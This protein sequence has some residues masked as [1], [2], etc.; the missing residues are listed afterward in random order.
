MSAENRTRS[1]VLIFHAT[2]V[3]G[4]E[5]PSSIYGSLPF[6]RPARTSV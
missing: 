3:V 1:A 6:G 4:A 5:R 2:L